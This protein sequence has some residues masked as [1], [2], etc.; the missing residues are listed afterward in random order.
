MCLVCG[1][2]TAAQEA[3]LAEE[4]FQRYQEVLLR[5]DVYA[6]LPTVLI[7]LKK[8]ENQPLLTSETIK[9][10]LADPDHLKLLIPDISDEFIAL[11]KTDA[12][13]RVMLSDPDVQL[14]LQDPE[15]IDELADLLEIE[16]SV[17]AAII[18]ERYRPLF[19]REDI[20]ELLPDVLI[21]LR[22][23][24]VQALLQPATIQ[25]IAEDPD[26]LKILV[27]E[28]EDR[29]I[30]LLKED[31]E[32]KVLINDPDLH[33]LLQN[34]I[35]IDELARL[36]TIEPST[37]TV[38]ITPASIAS[39]DIGERFTV[40]IDIANAEYVAGYQV[41]LQFDAAAVRYISWEQGTY[42][43]GSLFDVPATV[44]ADEIT[45]AS[46]AQMAVDAREGTLLTITFEVVKIKTSM[47]SLTEVVLAS[48]SSVSLPVTTQD[49]EIVEPPRPA[50]DVNKD[51]VINI[52]DLTL[53]ASHFGETGDI[54]ADVNGDGVVNI[55]DLTLVASHFGE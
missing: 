3:S 41:T 18:Y 6:V 21:L 29:F 48:A 38:S 4:I 11:L 42:L 30:T 8:P 14:L 2:Q 32:V 33:T 12:D 45:L 37:S 43:E 5:E 25:L 40:S 26:R 23:P 27:P 19:Q 20:R 50:W 17:L 52:L 13:I 28:I 47:L 51:G 53:V 44:G 9:A 22:D 54:D 34:P 24:E 49:A 55:L 35:E 36:L 39:P 1:M 31:A 7:E 16:R 46:T 10:V 15:A